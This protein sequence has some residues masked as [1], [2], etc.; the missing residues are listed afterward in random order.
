MDRA[1]QHYGIQILLYSPTHPLASPLF[2]ALRLAPSLVIPQETTLACI[3]TLLYRLNMV[4]NRGPSH[5][6]CLA[7]LSHAQRAVLRRLPADTLL[8]LLRARIQRGDPPP[9]SPSALT[10]LRP[11][12][13]CVIAQ[14]RSRTTLLDLPPWVLPV[15]ACD[16][17]DI[18]SSEHAL[19]V[20]PKYEVL[21]GGFLASLA[22]PILFNNI[23]LDQLQIFP[24]LA[25]LKRVQVFLGSASAGPTLLMDAI[26]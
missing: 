9:G 26:M 25:F 15:P 21:R 20:C 14:W 7:H 1:S 8:R 6:A 16:C 18:Q 24:L 10:S 2:G 23:V 4:S 5:E 19:L 12:Q 3:A 11:H 17:G 13:A 22:H